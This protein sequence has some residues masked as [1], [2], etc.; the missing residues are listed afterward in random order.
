MGS[1]DPGIV[2]VYTG[3]GKGKT[4][5][6]L[7]QALRACGWGLRVIVLQFLKNGRNSGELRSAAGL[8]NLKFECF[9]TGEF[10]RKGNPGPEDLRLASAG[11]SRAR[12]IMENRECDLLILDEINTAV[13]LGVVEEKDAI[14]LIDLRPGTI[15]LVLTGRNARPLV[16]QKADLVTEMLDVKHPFERGLEAR[17]GIEY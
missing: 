4:T 7:G 6:A 11:V 9:G 3:S 10:I 13:D 5:A 1:K 8:Q 16:I 12:E 15:D 2:Q 14:E 17:R